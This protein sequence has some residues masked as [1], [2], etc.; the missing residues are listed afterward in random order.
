MSTTTTTA[1]SGVHFPLLRNLQA[2]LFL[3]GSVL[4][5]SL[6]FRGKTARRFLDVTI[7]CPLAD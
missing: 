4:V 2:Y 7:V 6:Q 1:P 3:T 5:D